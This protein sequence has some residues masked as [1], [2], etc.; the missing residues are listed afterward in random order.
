MTKDT[1]IEAE[2]PLL[3]ADWFDP[4]E[5]G[6]RQRIRSFIENMLEEELA[7]TLGRGRYDRSADTAGHRNG[8]RDRQL[9]GTFGSMTVSVPRAR[10]TDSDGKQA[11]WRSKALPAYKRLTVQAERLIVGAYLA[12]TNTRRVRRALAALFGDEMVGEIGGQTLAPVAAR[13][14]DEDL[15]AGGVALACRF[16]RR[17]D[18]GFPLRTDPA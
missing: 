6:I 12:G 15:L 10:V 4:L 18:P 9:L 1:A 11:E 5:A 16:P 7:A 3:G 13:K 14:V 8:H 2:V 17:T